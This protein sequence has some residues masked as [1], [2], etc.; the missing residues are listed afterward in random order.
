MADINVSVTVDTVNITQE[1][2]AT[3]VVLTDDNG[4]HDITPG[5]SETFDI[6]T[7]INKTIK[8]TPSSQDGTT[9]T[10]DSFEQEN[11]V[12][13]FAELPSNANE[14][15]GTTASESVTGTELFKIYFTVEGKGQFYL[16]PELQVDQDG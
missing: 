16:D 11:E 10:F 2:V 13:A 3:T 7:G 1:N 4:D 15:T 6:V 9:V 8:F 12:N 5:D 14:W